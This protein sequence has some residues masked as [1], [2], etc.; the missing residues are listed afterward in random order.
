MRSGQMLGKVRVWLVA[1]MIVAFGA[2]SSTGVAGGI[3]NA[4]ELAKA[5]SQAVFFAPLTDDERLALGSAAALRYA[6]KGERIIEEGKH[7]DSMFVI[8]DGQAEVRVNRKTV[9]ILPEQSVVG[10]VEFLD[11]LPGSADV[12]LLGDTRLIELSYAKL[13]RLMNAR[14]RLGYLI[15]AG[16]ARIEAQRLRLMDQ[17][18][19]PS[20]E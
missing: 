11:G 7:P 10:E 17:K 12:T 18:E 9:A 20:S 5:L 19:A 13:T 4:P 2:V 16:L 15:M 8:L 14:P 1:A 6:K 3:A